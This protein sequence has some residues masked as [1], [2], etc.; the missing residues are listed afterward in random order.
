MLDELILELKQKDV[1]LYLQ[2]GKL[3]CKAPRDALTPDLKA[4]LQAHKAELTEYLLEVDQHREKSD[5]PIQRASRDKYLPLSYAQQRLW[6]LSQFDACSIA[7]NISSAWRLTGRV[8][9]T[10][11][12]RSLNEIVRRHEVLRTTFGMENGQPVQVI[13][14]AVDLDI[15]TKAFGHLPEDKR[16]SEIARYLDKQS[17]LPFDLTQGPLLRAALLSLS[18][19]DDSGQAEYI[20]YFAMHHIVSD[21]WSMSILNREFMSLYAAFSTNRASSLPEL[22]VQYADYAVWQREALQEEQIK[23]QL[24]YWK[25]QLAGASG[26]LELY[27]DRLRP[28]MPSYR[29][30]NYH[31]TVPE[32]IAA[33]LKTLGRQHDATL[34]MVLLSGLNILLYRY[35]GQRDICIGTPIANR[36]RLEIEG[37]IGFFVNIVVVRTV[38]ADNP[39]FIQLL[40]K[41]KK[42]CLEA[43]A[44]QGLPFERL[45]DALAPVRDM[46]HTPLF[47]VMFALQTVTDDLLEVGGVRFARLDMDTRSAKFDLSL[48]VIE[49][50]HGL[51]AVLNYN[52]DLFDEATIIQMAGNFRKLLETIAVS[53]DKSL[54]D[55]S[56]LTETERKQHL[57]EWN[58]VQ[59]VTATAQCIHQLFEA[60]VK[61]NPDAIA[62]VYENQQ[63][64]YS[65]L[66]A[67]ANQLAHYLRAHGVGPEVLVGIC[68]ERALEMVIGI[69][70]ILK[71][72]GAYV[73]FDPGYPQD[74]ITFMLD[75]ARPAAVLIHTATHQP[76]FDSVSVL[77]LAAQQE[78]IAHYSMDNPP[79]LCRTQNLAYVIYTSG[80]TGKP[81]GALATHENVL[82][83]FE[84]TQDKFGFD[85]HDVWTLFHSC[86]FDFS[87][88][89]LWGALIYGGK[90]VVVPYWISRSPEAFYRLLCEHSVTVLNQTPSAFRSLTHIAISENDGEQ[91]RDALRLVIFG[92]EALELES[93]KPWFERF[94]YRQPQLVNM[95]GITETTVHVTYFPLHS[96]VLGKS[97]GSPIGRPIED[98]QVYV[99][100][101]HYNLQPAGVPGELYVG[102]AGLVR[103]YL[104]RANLTAERFVPNP[105][106]VQ[107]GQRLY[108]TG[109]LARYRADGTIEYLGRIDQQVKIRGFRI[110][111]GEIEAAL[112]QHE[113]VKETT[114]VVREDNPGDKYLVG[115][116]VGDEAT[117]IDAIRAHLKSCLPEYMIPSAFVLLDKLPL[118][119]NGKVDRKALPAP[120][121]SDQ[122]AHG[123]VAPRNSAEEILAWVW[124]QILAVDHVGIDDNFFELG[125]DSIRSVQVVGLAKE[126]AL[127][128]S[129]EQLYRNPTIRELAQSVAKHAQ[130]DH[131]TRT[132]MPFD[133]VAFEDKTKF[134]EHIENAYPLTSLQAGMIFHSQSDKRAYHIFDSV[135]LQ[136]PFN[137]HYLESALTDVFNLHPI[138]RTVFDFENFSEPL[139][140]VHKKP[141]VS[142]QCSDLRHCDSAVQSDSVSAWRESEKCNYFN[143]DQLPLIRFH[144]HRLTDAQ[145]QFS[146]TEHHAVL[147]GWSLT[148]M[149]NEVFQRY[150]NLLESEMS[151]DEVRAIDDGMQKLVA[152]EK[153]ALAADQYRDYW[154][155][156]LSTLEISLLPQLSAVTAQKTTTGNH[157]NQSK[158]KLP[159]HL[160]DKLL[161][162][163]RT[164]GV[165]L[166]SVLL[167]AHIR[168][169]SVLLGKSNVT[170]GLV[171]NVRPETRDSEHALGVFLNTLPFSQKI[172]D[173]SWQE[174]ITQT[175]DLEC[176]LLQVRYYPLAALQRMR[177]NEP[178]FDVVFNYTHY[179]VGEDILQSNKLKMVEW[180]NAIPPN[181]SLEVG[182]DLQILS[183]EIELELSG[184]R[185]DTARLERIR[186]CFIAVF[187]H[188]VDN[189]A[190]SVGGHVFLSAVE[191]RQLH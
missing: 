121:I 99:L 94:G 68:T 16:D 82:R 13:A 53:P 153:N 122:L 128:F 4:T 172:T 72:G 119:T 58:A 115:Y 164:L 33:Q 7:Y 14:P 35:S 69:V 146:V 180:E 135:T 62:A 160:S 108:R 96:D 141:V 41:V 143:I 77:D 23:Q 97:L 59:P 183:S 155:R 178:L 174:F 67:K 105:F 42:V 75:D 184:S 134:S 92:G 152:I 85:K 3:R 25:Q 87:V 47:Q 100:D 40:T 157:W 185:I 52:T 175:F 106:N 1:Y 170:S 126:K 138:L 168:V 26:I 117:E 159:S 89:E 182:F 17:Q 50:R 186:D 132:L 190:A 156:Q 107:S 103:G 127:F 63:L 8:D 131:I 57:L 45:V 79:N 54:S 24:D 161:E 191:Q 49:C 110:E 44:H 64:S 150:F 137:Q 142:L 38:L 123:Y 12:S 20:L 19:S 162:L 28:N 112:L 71:A 22:D 129:V 43:Q 179:R 32:H 73:P 21:G 188:M 83:L 36:D 158:D 148:S 130:P 34:F 176:K 171:F 2:D 113:Q 166:K 56:L 37:L 124:V 27:A 165:P 90:L 88:W 66:N 140:L 111:L 80:S 39:T 51:D 81:K 10:A 118:T 74:R 11:L 163:A 154:I 65:Q 149:L 139:Q 177:G 151:S 18:A 173:A 109:D 147:D 31:F 84:N 29:G 102:G 60:R 55:L 120:N 86:A 61:E 187:N 133:L 93:L 70:G 5:L 169:L 48:E 46:R 181:F 145:F 91:R 144:V 101:A 78:E 125:G 136:C 30:S 189:P 98:L 114:V 95:Y 116:V 6:T 9:V 167:A 104:S 15:A 76:L